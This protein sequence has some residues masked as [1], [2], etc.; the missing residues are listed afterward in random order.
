[1]PMTVVTTRDVVPRFRGFLASCMLEIAP[2][3]Y[4]ASRMNRAVRERVWAV[5][6]DWYGS[7]GG[8]SIVMVWADG[9]APS[10]QGLAV[11]GVPPVT[12]ED[13]GGVLLTHRL[14]GSGERAETPPDAL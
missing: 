4:T 9:K 8:G 2:G 3:V 14:R 11:L 5:L 12:I 1:M 10:G 13:V 6:V 7:L